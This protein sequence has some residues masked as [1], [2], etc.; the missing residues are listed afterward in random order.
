[1]KN[2]KPSFAFG[3]SPYKDNLLTTAQANE[4]TTTRI[5]DRKGVSDM[6]LD[7]KAKSKEL[8]TAAGRP[9]INLGSI[10]PEHNNYKPQPLDRNNS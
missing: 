3:N 1:M 4:K 5:V 8:R 7:L 2:E 9:N 6:N 10:L